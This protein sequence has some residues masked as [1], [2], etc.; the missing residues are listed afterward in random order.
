[1]ARRHLC[2]L[3][4]FAAAVT[5][6]APS[7]R[8]AAQATGGPIVISQVYGGGGNAGATLRNDFI[9]V[10][11]RSG[12]PV[13][14]DGWSVQYAS[15]AGTTWLVTPLTGS[16]QPGAYY[17]I[18]QAAGTGGTVDLPTPDAS[19]STAMAAGSGKVALVSA[20]APL[21][22]A[23]PASGSLVDFVGYG[24]A[25]CSEG[26]LTAPGLGNATAALRK[27]NG[28]Q[29][30]NNNASDFEELSPAPRNSAAPTESCAPPTL[31]LPH[32]IQG[33]GAVSPFAGQLS[34]VEGVVTA[35]KFNGFFVQT[36]PEREDGDPTTS[37][38]LFVFTG[39][40][41]PAEALVGHL[42]RATGRIQE[43][44]PGADPGSPPVTELIL[45]TVDEDLG[46]A[47]MPSS[48]ALSATLPDPAG[49]FDQL[50]RFEGMRVAVASL[51]VVGPTQ[52]D[53]LEP[54]DTGESNGAFYT[55]VTGVPRP[56][57]EPGIPVS[58]P[59]PPCGGCTP[60]RFDTNP[61]LL[62]VD[63]D[64]LEGMPTLDVATGAT[65]A[66]VAGV[67]DYG[68][69]TF[70]ILPETP[71][72]PIGGLVA[73]PVRMP[74][75]T[76]F[77]VATANV[78]R[79]FD[80]TNDPAIGEPVATPEAYARR[81]AKLSRLVREYLRLPDLIGVQEVES[82]AVLQD[83]ASRINRDAGLGA[84]YVAY[85]EEGN[86]PG[87]IDVGLLV[88][89]TRVKNVSV[90][91]VGKDATFIDPM[92]GSVD[93]L[94]DRPSLVLRGRI[95]GPATRFPADV[96][97]VVNH[98]RSLNDVDQDPGAGPRV[99]EKRRQQAEFLATLLDS[100]QDEGAVISVGDYNA[101]EV[102]DGY[103]DVLGTII[104]NPTPADQVVLASP[105]LVEPNL[106]RAARPGDYSYVFGGSA[107]SLDHILLSSR[108][109]A[110]AT[111]FEQA[112][113]NADFPEALRHLLDPVTGQ[114]PPERESDHDPAVA[115]FAFPP[116]TEAPIIEN[117]PADITVTATSPAGAL[118]T[119]TAPTATDNLDGPVDVSCTPSSGATIPIGVTTVA[120]SA[121]DASGNRASASFAVTVVDPRTA[122]VLTGVG[123]LTM[124]MGRVSFFVA[125]LESGG[126]QTGV[127]A[128][129]SQR[130]GG[131]DTFAVLQTNVV[132]FLPGSREVILQGTGFWNG[133]SG[134]TFEIVA[135]DNGEP[136]RHRDVFSI[137]VRDP[138]GAEV[139]RAGG[140]LADG[141]IR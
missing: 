134:H 36:Q 62:R 127:A 116:D 70:T 74:D 67:L 3:L 57:R 112:H 78:Q 91:Q 37:E 1:M 61:E 30:T 28:C 12:A 48:I 56:F 34:A 133:R 35:R 135:E 29:D 118:V 55:V 119:W 44:V 80:T 92:D 47:T 98:L 2:V 50:E 46:A 105:D 100:L 120:C 13:L 138:S 68:F 77:T 11:N 106:G 122:G 33:A 58:A 131:V 71:V 99:R 95:E 14:L 94:N 124:P 75:A 79:F 31:R 137:L 86:D 15:S 6:S 88:R 59:V 89:S 38:G 102:N 64:A 139:L 126:V 42:V 7:T 136:G 121:S 41:P 114:P 25:N 110:L 27:L 39:S 63:S 51:T 40:A 22:G 60:P 45:S 140:T 10:F 101:F 54:T 8:L 115:Y 93:V 52:G 49:A 24:T 96:I 117:V 123:R 97:L 76:E 69:R 72:T 32:E 103:V 5:C 111:G 87:G 81:L 125:A 26:G 107:Q 16:I 43:F 104:G 83:I 53:V 113:V 130:A 23:C 20:A 65:L 85:L 132:F 128:I 4:G 84:D 9:E 19:G 90:T 18:R 82:L 141:N 108:A 66:D 73:T 21:Q 109:A 17:L 129:T